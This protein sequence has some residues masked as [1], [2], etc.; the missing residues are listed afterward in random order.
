MSRVLLLHTGGTLG[1]RPRQPDLALE[2]DEIGGALLSHVPELGELAE[3][4]TRVLCNVDSSDMSSSHWIQI[5]EE[6]HEA[7]S[8]ET[9]SYDGVVITHGTDTMA[10]TAC[11]LSYQ[12]RNLPRPV[13]LTGSQRPLAEPSTDA[14]A[15]LVGAVDLATRGVPEVAIYFH[16][17]LLRGN[18]SVKR[19]NFAY[20][21]FYSPNYPVLAEVGTE[22]HWV[23]EQ[24]FP[25]GP[26]SRV[27]AFDHRV[28]VIKLLPQQDASMLRC[29]VG[30]GLRALVLGAFGAGNIPVETSGVGAAIQEL[31]DAGTWVCIGSA[32]DHGRVDMTRYAGGILAQK[33]GALG[34]HD[35]TVEAA[36]IK[37]MYLL[38]TLDAEETALPGIDSATPTLPQAFKTPLA[39]EV[40]PQ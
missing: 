37:L 14:R 22:I 20:G 28:G 17:Q 38:G 29:L 39:G 11:A 13:I 2:P 33:S 24:L 40:T 3:I 30:A 23:G 26:F 34:I 15:N 32:S 7:L 9:P 21:A 18:R 31:R 36:S 6:I 5:A 19:S 1:M 10:Y 12:L 35:M 27:G 8:G 4:E 16:G 25:Q